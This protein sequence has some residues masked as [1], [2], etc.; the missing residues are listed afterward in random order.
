MVTTRTQQ[1]W[2]GLGVLIL[3][4]LWLMSLAHILCARLKWRIVKSVIRI[5]AKLKND[6]RS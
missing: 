4:E 3:R 5:A 1:M 6:L 2:A